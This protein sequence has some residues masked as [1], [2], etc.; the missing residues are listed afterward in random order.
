MR[1]LKE[2]LA[3]QQCVI[4]V[5]G[6]HAGESADEIFQRKIADIGRTGRT[7]W[8]MKSPKARPVQ[9][10]EICRIAPVY[11]I[12]IEPATKGGAQPTI[13]TDEA[14]EYSE[15]KLAWH[16]LPEDMSPV[17]G[18]LDAGAAALVFGD[19]TTAVSGKLDL[20]NYAVYRDIQKP[21]KFRLGCST[22]CAVQKNMALD[23]EKMK[24]RYREIAAVAR[25]AEPYCVWL[26]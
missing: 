5:M 16:Q 14:G 8:V 9:V 15:N 24:S 18:K 10:Q 26:R 22:V 13:T 2:A 3:C 4:S 11:A 20:W 1:L 12:F 7:F 19:M 23:P 6:D 25:L 17:T 21:L